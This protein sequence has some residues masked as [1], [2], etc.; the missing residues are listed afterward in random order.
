MYIHRGMHVYIHTCIYAYVYAHL[1]MHICL[2]TYGC[3]FAYK[4][5]CLF[6]PDMHI[7]I[8]LCLY[9]CIS[10]Q[11]YMDTYIFMYICICIEDAARPTAHNNLLKGQIDALVT[12]AQ[13]ETYICI[14]MLY[15]YTHIC[16]NEHTD[17][18]VYIYICT[19]M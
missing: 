2:C 15:I 12:K 5:L 3:T 19:Y 8:H 18:Y 10:K 11:T 7:Y 13:E 4:N 14:Y 9:V 16:M 1:F 6:P 17:V